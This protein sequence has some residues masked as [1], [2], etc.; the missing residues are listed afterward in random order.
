MLMRKVFKMGNDYTERFISKF[1]SDNTL[2]ISADI[3]NQINNLDVHE[4]KNYMEMIG[5][6]ETGLNKFCLL[7]TS[8]S[9]RDVHLSRMPS[10]A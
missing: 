4:K 6:K 8:P 5:L 9:P 2:I 7:Y 1:G 10:S 3:E